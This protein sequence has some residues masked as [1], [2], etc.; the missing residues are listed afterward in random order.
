MDDTLSPEEM[1]R[2]RDYRRLRTRNPICL[3]CGYHNHPA[4]MELAH[5]APHKF[6]DDAGVL[7]SNCHREVSDPEKDLPYAP[8]TQNPQI[9]TIGRYLLA[10]AEWFERIARTIAE[11]GAFLLALAERAPAIEIGVTT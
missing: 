2:E 3:H 8:Q 9:E 1:R 11:F 10:L 4:A 5:I 7:C 6:H